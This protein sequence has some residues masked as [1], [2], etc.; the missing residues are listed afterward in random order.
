MAQF[1]YKRSREGLGSAVHWRGA[2]GALQARDQR[3]E[4][5][6]VETQLA[7]GRDL[8]EESR[9][10]LEDGDRAARA[11]GRRALGARHVARLAKAVAG[12]EHADALAVPL[13]RTIAGHQDVEAIV[14]LAFLDDLL[15]VGVVLPAARAQNLPDLRVRELVEK[16]Q[17]PQHTELLLAVDARIGL[18]QSLVD[19][20][21]LGGELQ[22]AL[23]ALLGVLL[24]RGRHYVLELLRHL[25]A[26]GVDRRRRG[27]DDLVQQLLQI[28]GAEG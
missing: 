15:A 13:D 24:Q 27:V 18:A 14:H 25:L 28:A 22:S 21:E 2:L 9:A 8:L 3:G 20:S 23:A 5:D 16:L 4:E 10:H 26:Q 7:G 17:P 6:P 19:A 1:A 11:D 12:V